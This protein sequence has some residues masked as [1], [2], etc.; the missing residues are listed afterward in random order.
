MSVDLIVVGS[1]NMDLVMQ[2]LDFPLPGQT[3]VGTGFAQYHGGK[4]ANQAVAAARSGAQVTM[5]GAVGNDSYGTQLTTALQAEGIDTTAMIER[6]DTATGVANIWVNAHG[7][8]SILLA[9]GANDTLTASDVNHSFAHSTALKHAKALLVQGEVP[10]AAS[11][12]ALRIA[13]ERGWLRC[14]NP[15]P[16]VIGIERL[17][18]LC[19]VLVLNETEAAALLKQSVAT[20]TQAPRQAAQAIQNEFHCCDIV[21]TLGALGAC[22]SSLQHQA[23]FKHQPNVDYQHYP[24][25][26]VAVLDTTAAGDTLTGALL[27]RLTQGIPFSIAL[28]YA[29][30]AAGICVSRR[31]A[32]AS[33]PHGK[34][35]ILIG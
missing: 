4:G 24:A 34:D 26:S 20:V 2:C 28:Q 32:Q 11:E 17:I 10:L 6:C 8:N 18:R 16:F 3:V 19:D 5:L 25:A 30:Q 29:I 15:A 1:L 12:A 31:G 9:S 23:K 7:E 13:G 21:L 14:V 33:I 22:H 35:G 27:A